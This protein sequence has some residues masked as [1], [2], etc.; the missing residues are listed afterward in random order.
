MKF[1]TN[2]I[3]FPIFVPILE[4]MIQL[5][6]HHTVRESDKSINFEDFTAWSLCCCYT[7]PCNI[8]AWFWLFFQSVHPK[9]LINPIKGRGGGKK[10]PIPPTR[11]SSV[12]SSNVGIS[13]QN[14]WL[15]VLTLLTDW[16]KISSFYLVPVPNYWTWTKTT[17]QKKRFF[18]SN[19]YKIEVMITSLIQML[20]LPNFGHMTT[21]I[22]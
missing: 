9:I 6:V 21:S 2:S 11:F 5:S 18:W 4:D 10:T 3:Y 1:P 22:I 15:L 19:P 12:T 7:T 20:E 17:P 13:P 8:Y 16:C 14:F